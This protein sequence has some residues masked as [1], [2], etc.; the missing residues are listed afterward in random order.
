MSKT[1]ENWNLGRKTGVEAL[2][3]DGQQ[4]VAELQRYPD[5]PTM[6]L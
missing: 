3:K 5:A 1:K 6:A 4:R 2:T